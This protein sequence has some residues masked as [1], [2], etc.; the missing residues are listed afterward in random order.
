MDNFFDLSNVL[1]QSKNTIINTVDSGLGNLQDGFL[2]TNFGR[3][4]DNAFNSAL[5][6][7]LPDFV[8]NQVIDVKDAILQEGVKA[9]V[10]EAIISSLD[11]GKSILGIFTGKF[12]NISQI[13]NAIKKGGLIDAI[14]S[15]LD[16]AIDMSI[17]SGLIDK[18]VGKIISSGKK[19]ILKNVSSNIENSLESQVSSIEKLDK[20]CEKWHEA[21]KNQD[22]SEMDKLFKSINKQ[23]ENII[24]LESTINKAREIENLQ[25][26]IKNNGGDFNISSD[27][28]ELAK[29][30]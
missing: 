20:Y 22:V 2:K 27:A 6:T 10:N 7:M 5:R 21:Y 25:N 12:E 3:L 11:L 1:E 8:E 16:K 13:Q 23:L 9:G 4:V 24:P 29:V 30:L 17:S 14:S 19:A 18:S 26:L 15:V 28:L